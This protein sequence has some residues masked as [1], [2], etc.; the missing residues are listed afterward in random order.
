[1]ATGTIGEEEEVAVE[2]EV[3]EN[4]EEVGTLPQQVVMKTGSVM[5]VIKGGTWSKFALI[6]CILF[7]PQPVMSNW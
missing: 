2:E 5:G 6:T 4:K 1:M 3:I 7:V